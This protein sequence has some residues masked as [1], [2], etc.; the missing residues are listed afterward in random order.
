MS[1]YLKM[2]DTSDVI[3]LKTKSV[4]DRARSPDYNQ[5]TGHVKNDVALEFKAFCVKERISISEGMELAL[6]LF[7]TTYQDKEKLEQAKE[8]LN[9]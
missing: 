1:K 2:K 7:L 4:V 5:V 9:H 3:I 8:S 6:S